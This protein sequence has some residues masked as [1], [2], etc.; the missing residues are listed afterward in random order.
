MKNIR[1]YAVCC[2]AAALL[3]CDNTSQSVSSPDEGVAGSAVSSPAAGASGE[4]EKPKFVYGGFFN[5]RNGGAY[6]QLLKVCRRCG[7]KRVT[8]GGGYQRIWVLGD[9]P[10][11]CRHWLQ[12]GYLQVVFKEKKLPTQATVTLQ[13]EY[14]HSSCR[15]AQ[16][17]CF[18]HP[19]S[20][21][22]T[23]RPINKNKGFAITLSPGGGLG[24]QINL[25]IR[26]DATRHVSQTQLEVYG[27]YGGEGVSAKGGRV[28]K[29]FLE[30]QEGVPIRHRS[31]SCGSYPQN[32]FPSS[33]QFPF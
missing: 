4:Q 22:G 27:S 19:F 28:L 5:I 7:T 8:P 12:S 10:V 25:Y 14:S 20:V 29:A 24:G 15:R 13:P 23:A 9:S 17:R 21:Q 33:M 3:S 32:P 31:L 2:V 30:K 18:G 1:L 6:E 16:K 11:K 26:S